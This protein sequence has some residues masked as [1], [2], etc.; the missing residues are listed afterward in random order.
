MCA[1]PAAA[2]DPTAAIEGASAKVRLHRHNSKLLLD[3]SETAAAFG[4]EA[5]IVTPGKLLTICR[6][7]KIDGACIPVQLTRV[8]S[9]TIEGRLFVDASVLGSSLGFRV[10]ESGDQVTLRRENKLDAA[11]I[12]AYNDTW[13]KGRGFRAGQTLPDIPLYDMQGQEVRFSKFLG[14]QYI[15]YCWASW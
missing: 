9:L 12:S 5:K 2:A 10:V 13:D 3:A 1:L 6:K 14:K 11:G 7:G 15:V 4:W 8:A